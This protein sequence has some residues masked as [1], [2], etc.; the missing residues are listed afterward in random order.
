MSEH[1]EK[2]ESFQ[3]ELNGI[4][5]SDIAHDELGVANGFHE[6]QVAKN[7]A[8]DYLGGVLERLAAHLNNLNDAIVAEKL[9]QTEQWFTQIKKQIEQI[10]NLAESG[11][12]EAN[13]PNQ[14][15]KF[16]SSVETQV[17]NLKKQLYPLELDLKLCE[18]GTKLEDYEYFKNAKSK[19]TQLVS[20]AESASDQI[21]K[22]LA[23]VQDKTVQSGVDES[24]GQFGELLLH[25]RAYERNWLIATAVCALI[26]CAAVYYAI[27]AFP[28]LPSEEQSL[29]ALT[30]AFLKRLVLI[31]IAGVF[32][33]ISL[34]K[35]NTERGLHIVY[36]HRQ[37]VLDQYRTFEAGIGDDLE[38]KNRFRLEIAKY[39]FSDPQSAYSSTGKA[40]ST[41]IN[42]N[43]VVSAVEKIARA[44]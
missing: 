34:T 30:V 27:A 5:E 8:C 35:Y 22:I 21:K 33:R 19:A 2:I 20:D 1:A 38:A 36:G 18:L 17:T 39:I 9:A 43:P 7:S 28:S 16:I 44:K 3:A 23:A 41:D 26:L 37:K 31:S 12:H 40:T 29:A 24:S 32:V 11:V 15:T 14:R 42:I 10:N 25:H 6:A 4:L 13:F